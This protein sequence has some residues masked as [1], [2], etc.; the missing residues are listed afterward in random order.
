MPEVAGPPLEAETIRRMAIEEV[1]LLLTP[2]EIDALAAML[3]QLFEEI[4]QILSH[5]RAG[6]EPEISASV[7]EWPA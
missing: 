4:R 7:Q 6:A 2:A 3:P 1:M 5:D